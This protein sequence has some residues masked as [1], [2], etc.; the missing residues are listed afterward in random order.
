[1]KRL[2]SAVLGV[3]LLLVPVSFLFAVLVPVP[4][5]RKGTPADY[6]AAIASCL[7]LYGGA[8]LGIFALRS[9][10]A[11]KSPRSIFQASFI[12]AVVTV[13]VVTLSRWLATGRSTGAS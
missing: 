13:T 1:M 11:A 12:G 10:G 6:S 2:I 5:Y 9:R 7:T 4:Q 3:L 8:A